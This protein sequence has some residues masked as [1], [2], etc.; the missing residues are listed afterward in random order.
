MPVKFTKVTTAFLQ[1]DVTSLLARAVQILVD[2]ALAN[3]RN[4]TSQQ[5]LRQI[6]ETNIVTDTEAHSNSLGLSVSEL[7]K[8]A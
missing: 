1:F 7:I 8:H 6:A 2:L 4:V 3:L 5:V